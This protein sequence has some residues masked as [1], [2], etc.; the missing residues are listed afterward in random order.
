M[1]YIPHIY[2]V[3]FGGGDTFEPE[4]E[5]LAFTRWE[6]ALNACLAN[7]DG[8]IEN[9]DEC[10][11]SEFD[12]DGPDANDYRASQAEV[13]EVRD[14]AA[15][16]TA[17]GI[18]HTWKAAGWAFWILDAVLDENDATVYVGSDGKTRVYDPND[19]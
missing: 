11:G 4:G 12:P 10:I 3:G 19:G 13:Q 1:T 8:L 5:T 18:G 15:L 9:W 7:M 6:E 14:S 17:I 2:V 16:A